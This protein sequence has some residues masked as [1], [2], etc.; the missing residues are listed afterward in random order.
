[1][2][3][4]E[5]TPILT[6]EELSSPNKFG[7]HKVSEPI[8]AKKYIG[9]NCF[10][11]F[12]SKTW[13]LYPEFRSFVTTAQLEIPKEAIVIKPIDSNDLRTDCAI[14]KDIYLS[15]NFLPEQC[16]CFSHHFPNFKYKINAKH[17]PEH[18]LN[19]K[20]DLIHTSGIHFKLSDNK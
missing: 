19:Q 5:Y 14:V 12:D 16:K 15:D 18:P 17:Y 1:M 3:N 4:P 6:K 10:R 9:C 8:E 2:S 11:L 20:V 13:S 7:L